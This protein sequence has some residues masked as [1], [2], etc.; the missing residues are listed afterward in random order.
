MTISHIQ[1][2]VKSSLSITVE[3]IGFSRIGDNCWIT[4]YD[5]L[6]CV[7]NGKGQ[8]AT[9]RLTPRLSFAEV[10]DDLIALKDR[11]LSQG[12]VLKRVLH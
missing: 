7:L 3:N 11:L 4:Q 9:W 8:V 2:H 10:Q 6:F 5:T 12:K 1:W